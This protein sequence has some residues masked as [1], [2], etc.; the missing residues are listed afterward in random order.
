MTNNKTNLKRDLNAEKVKKFIYLI[1][2]ASDRDT[3]SLAQEMLDRLKMKK[4]QYIQNKPTEGTEKS[5][6]G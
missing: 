6:E 1:A 4:Y 3:L 5:K 2:K